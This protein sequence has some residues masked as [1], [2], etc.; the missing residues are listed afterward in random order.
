MASYEYYPE[1]RYGMDSAFYW[2]RI[3]LVI[4]D[5]TRK[6]YDNSWALGQAWLYISAASLTSFLVYKGEVRGSSPRGPTTR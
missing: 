4:P 6:E 2:Y 1:T 3:W 5:D